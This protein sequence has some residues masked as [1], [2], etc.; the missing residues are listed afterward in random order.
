VNQEQAKEA[1]DIIIQAERDLDQAKE[2]YKATVESAVETYELT[3]DQA[4][5]AKQVA[6]AMLKDK[7]GD[8]EDKATTLLELVDVV[9]K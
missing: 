3:P 2:D 4:K 9:K 1:L 5:A 6:K 8:I 7:V